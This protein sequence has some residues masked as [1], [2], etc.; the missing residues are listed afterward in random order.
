MTMPGTATA[1]RLLDGRAALRFPYDTWVIEALKL[2]VPPFA[3]SYD[4]AR[5]TWTVD[6]PWVDRAVAILRE[7]F[8]R[9][10]VIA[11]RHAREGWDDRRTG[12][13]ITDRIRGTDHYQ[14]LHLLPTAPLEVIEVVYRTLARRDHP[15]VGGDTERM[16]QINIAYEVLK[17]RLAS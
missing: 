16:K 17:A 6:R 4:P 8:G 9:V 13:T 10:E 12:S 5:K 7:A 2:D 11:E 15:D 1:T 3:R 14:T